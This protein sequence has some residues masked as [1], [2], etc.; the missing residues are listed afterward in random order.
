MNKKIIIIAWRWLSLGDNELE[1]FAVEND[2]HVKTYERHLIRVKEP[3]GIDEDETVAKIEAY[4][5]ENC[6]AMDEI[7]VFL[8]EQKREGRNGYNQN[9]RYRLLE[10]NN[11]KD[12]HYKIRCFMFSNNCPLYKILLKDGDFRTNY[13]AKN[14][15]VK[16]PMPIVIENYTTKKKEITAVPFNKVWKY[17]EE[18][19]VEHEEYIRALFKDCLNHWVK[20]PDNEDNKKPY[21]MSHWRET[22]KDNEG[23]FEKF[24]GFLKFSSKPE[25]VTHTTDTEEKIYQ[26]SIAYIASDKKAK[27]A[28]EDLKRLVA[29]TDESEKKYSL[30]DI[31]RRMDDIRR[32]IETP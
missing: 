2:K 1:E 26:R 4:I 16:M 13:L 3:Y 8:H 6:N 30:K 12:V 5:T 23:L 27:K 28:Y 20:I 32:R 22:L 14:F 18:Q 24:N 29:L 19:Y 31:W 25:I 9:A 17:Y 21:P 10:I 11:Q 15:N 7:F